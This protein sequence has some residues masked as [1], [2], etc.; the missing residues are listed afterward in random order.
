MHL[1]SEL[2]CCFRYKSNSPSFQMMAVL[3]MS[4]MLRYYTLSNII[5]TGYNTLQTNTTQILPGPTIKD[6][7]ATYFAGLDTLVQFSSDGIVTYMPVSPND[8]NANTQ[9]SWTRVTAV[10]APNSTSTSNSTNSTGSGV[11]AQTAAGSSPST[12]S[13]PNGDVGYQ[14][15]L[16]AA[17][18]IG[19][20]AALSLI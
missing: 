6:A 20:L 16:S 15:P 14:S 2:I 1:Y 5:F 13:S 19:M 3:P 8:T 18:L 17:V 9:A 10:P 4:S 11:G 12:T 7:N